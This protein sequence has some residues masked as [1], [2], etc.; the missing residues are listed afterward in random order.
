MLLPSKKLIGF[1]GPILQAGSFSFRSS[2]SCPAATV[3]QIRDVLHH[4]WSGPRPRA[5]IRSNWRENRLPCVWKYCETKWLSRRQE[6]KTFQ[7]LWKEQRQ[8]FNQRGRV[9]GSCILLRLPRISSFTC[10]LSLVALYY[11]YS[12]PSHLFCF[13]L[14]CWKLQ[15]FWPQLTPEWDWKSLKWWTAGVDMNLVQNAEFSTPKLP[16][17]CRLRFFQMLL[18]LT[19]SPVRSPAAWSV[20]AKS[21]M[22]NWRYWHCCD[23]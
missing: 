18:A 4:T 13:P 5:M 16:N 14:S 22:H 10:H 15:T 17:Q 2:P 9:T 23:I 7:V 3:P 6:W 1:K 8:T 19:P 11:S 12:S 21:S 20:T